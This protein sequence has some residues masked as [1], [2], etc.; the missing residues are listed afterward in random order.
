M[1]TIFGKTSNSI[2]NNAFYGA[3]NNNLEDCDSTDIVIF[4]P[5][6]RDKLVSERAT[7]NRMIIT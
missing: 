2:R 1:C 7:E 6:N 4:E 3:K 5:A